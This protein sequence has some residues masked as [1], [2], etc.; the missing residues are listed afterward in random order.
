MKTHQ[1]ETHMFHDEGNR[2]NPRRA[3]SSRFTI[4]QSRSGVVF[5]V[6]L[7][8]FLVMAVMAFSL[9]TFKGGAI[10]QLSKSIDQNR[11]AMLAQAANNEI[12]AILRSQVNKHVQGGAENGFYAVFRKAINLE[13]E[14]NPPTL[15]WTANIFSDDYTPVLTQDMVTRAGYNISLKSQAKL[16]LD[17]RTTVSGTAG[18]SGYLEIVSRASHLAGDQTK[19]EVKERRDIKVVDM[20]H[21]FDRYALYVKNYSPDWNNPRRRVVVKGIPPDFS[22]GVYSTVYV[23]NQFYP[24]SREYSSSAA[25]PRLWFDVCFSEQENLIAPLLGLPASAARTVFPGINSDPF[26]VFFGVSDGEYLNVAKFGVSDFY[27][28]KQIKD[29]FRDLINRSADS[30]LKTNTFVS[31]PALKKK[32]ADALNEMGGN[33]NSA[34]WVLCDDYHSNV[35]EE[36]TDFSKSKAFNM[37]VQTCIDN[38][39]Y[40]WGYTDA[41]TSWNLGSSRRLPGPSTLM[42]DVRLVGLATQSKE[43][44][45]LGP[46]MYQN[47]RPEDDSAHAPWNPERVF[48]GKMAKLCGPSANIPLLV[49]GN[50]FL[51][52]FKIAYFDEM[53][54]TFTLLGDIKTSCVLAPVPL[55]YY[56]CDDILGQADTF[57]NKPSTEL[58]NHKLFS[59]CLPSS[60]AAGYIE[61]RAL[62][63]RAIDTIPLNTMFTTGFVKVTKPDGSE[64]MYDSTADGVIPDPQQVVKSG[65]SV[66]PGHKMFRVVDEQMCSRNYYDPASFLRERVVREGEKDTLYID[67]YMY[68]TEGDLDLSWVEQ[69]AGRGLIFLGKGNCKIGNF[70][71]KDGSDSDQ[72]LRILLLDGDFIVNSS[73]SDV[74]IEASLIATTYISPSAARDPSSLTA[75]GSFNP[76]NKR[77]KILGNLVV[78]YLFTE[79]GSIGLPNEGTLTIEHDPMIYNPKP[80][81]N[82][83]FRASIGAVRTMFSMNAEGRE[84]F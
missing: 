76:N 77:V 62:M 41:S 17:K 71:K 53:N 4:L 26:K 43:T 1:S 7:A 18:F 51:R 80:P 23:G 73:E 63:S 83:P 64:A 25:S 36:G 35:S 68:I 69:F 11:L 48:V 46:W 44:N 59:K 78:D 81:E 13:V 9:S 56:R 15:P 5:F 74:K 30:E 84:S 27:E 8:V 10:E 2:Y 16:V 50:A 47:I 55:D 34:A 39:V 66:K 28:V 42:N 19:I 21:F 37:I 45:Q 31:G 82:D 6:V 65:K 60:P 14:G 33:R 79:S 40:R 72:T 24:K 57:L 54:A 49:E 52:F 12:V 38:W 75:Q 29:Q 3:A 61:D 67:G 20:R 70:M 22:S 58:A 32:C